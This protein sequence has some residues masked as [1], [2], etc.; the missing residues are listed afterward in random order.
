MIPKRIPKATRYLG[1]PVGWK[2]EERGPC[3]H[4]AIRDMDTTAGPA[5]M[6]LWEPTPDE[7]ERLNLGA[8]V[9]LLVIG[10]VHAPVMIAVGT[11]PT[12]DASLA[13]GAAG[14]GA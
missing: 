9:S 13:P 2:P 8:P 11:V 5:M 4:L 12:D 14:G 3:A 10:Q 1:A 6:S 7:L